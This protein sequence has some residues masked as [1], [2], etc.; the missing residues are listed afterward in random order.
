MSYLAAAAP[1]VSSALDLA[2]GLF[3]SDSTSKEGK[4]NRAFQER[5]DNTKHVRN[6]Y[7]L[8]KAGINPMLPYASG[9]GVGSAPSGSMPTIQNPASGAASKLATA[10]L[11]S[12]QSANLQASTDKLNAETDNTKATTAKILAETPNV[13]KTGQLIDAQ[14][15]KIAHEIPQILRQGNLTDAQTHN[16]WQVTANLVTQQDL[17]RAQIRQALSSANLSAEQIRLITPQI[18]KLH[19]E[20]RSTNAGVGYKEFTSLPGDL[21]DS[22]FG[23]SAVDVNRSS[24]SNALRTAPAGVKNFYERLTDDV[25]NQRKQID[26][27]RGRK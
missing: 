4:R 3:A 6:V 23:N 7:D 5:M 9:G 1:Y 27:E 20:I 22:L 10:P 14:R 8:K 2:G 19:A 18:E 21:L 17:T 25:R 13:S 16:T 11:V 15:E 26:K 12:A 24:T